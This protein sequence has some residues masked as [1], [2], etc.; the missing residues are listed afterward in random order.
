MAQQN[1]SFET[2]QS[3]PHLNLSAHTF[4]IHTLPFHRI[5]SILDLLT[6]DEAATQD[7]LILDRINQTIVNL[8]RQL[9]ENHWLATQRFLAL[10]QHRLAQRLPQYIHDIQQLDCGHCRL[11]RR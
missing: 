9:N 6:S 5:S 7:L 2:I 1:L 4:A 3:T 10:L 8:E 11:C